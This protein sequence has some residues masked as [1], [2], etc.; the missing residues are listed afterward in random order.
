MKRIPTALALGFAASI[1]VV[2]LAPPAQADTPGCVTKTEFRAV[3]KGDKKMRVHRI[4]DTR[5]EFA[6]GFAGGYTRWY[7]SC[8]AV[9]S[10]GSDAGAYV[11]YQWLKDG[12]FR[13]VEKRWVI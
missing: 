2:V 10:G 7:P 8:R 4:F 11:S 1:G 6:D 12:T 3:K 13:V 9:A 5:G